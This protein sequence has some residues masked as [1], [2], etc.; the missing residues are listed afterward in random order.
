MWQRW[1]PEILKDTGL[2]PERLVL[3]ITEGLMMADDQGIHDQLDNI[4]QQGVGLAIDDFGT[5]YSSLS[6]LKKFPINILKID[7]SFVKDLTV[8]PDDDELVKGILSMAQSL[9][10][11][12]VAEG[13]ENQEQE[14]FLVSNQCLFTQGYYYS[15][16]LS[17][18]DFERYLMQSAEAYRSA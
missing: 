2:E 18:P 9:K 13:V 10:L 6:Y 15:R 11:Q 1:L 3:E 7:R 5:G 14:A 4:R 17:Q 12:V 8:D 16:P